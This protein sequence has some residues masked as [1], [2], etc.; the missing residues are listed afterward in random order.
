VSWLERRLFLRWGHLATTRMPRR[1]SLEASEPR[2]WYGA[3]MPVLCN[4]GGP[5]SL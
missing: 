1:A 4:H 2:L 5:G 3:G